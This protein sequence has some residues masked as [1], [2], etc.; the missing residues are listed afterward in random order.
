MAL[1]C[2]LDFLLLSTFFKFLIFCKLINAALNSCAGLNSIVC[3]NFAGSNFIV[4]ENN[5]KTYQLFLINKKGRKLFFLKI[6]ILVRLTKQIFDNNEFILFIAIQ[7]KN[8]QAKQWENWLILI[9]IVHFPFFSQRASQAEWTRPAWCA[10]SLTEWN[11]F[12]SR[13]APPI[14]TSH[15]CQTWARRSSYRSE[16]SAKSES[17]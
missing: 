7:C 14:T 9:I 12:T 15:K 4:H 8:L 6:K 11:R 3:L 13:L 5:R 17:E 16:V 10:R 2:F 1:E